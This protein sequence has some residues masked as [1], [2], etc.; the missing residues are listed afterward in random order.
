MET[1]A[2]VIFEVSFEVC[3]KVGGIYAV[4]K[5]K[6]ARMMEHYKENYFLIGPYFKERAALETMK[7]TPPA[8]MKEAFSELEK[9]GIKC[10]Y[11][12]WLIPS[13]PNVILIDY[14]QIMGNSNKLKEKLWQDYKID[15]W[16]AG[17]DFDEPV[18][19]S[20]AAGM[21]IEKLAGKM[22]NKKIVCQF[23]EWLSG[24]GMLYLKGKV[25]TVFTTHATMLGRTIAGSG[26]DL[27]SEVNSGKPID[28]KRSYK[29]GMQ[30][31]HLTEKA[32]AESCNVFTTVS[33]ITGKEAEYILGKKPDVLLPNGLDSSKF[34]TMEEL[35]LSHRKYR[36]KIKDFLNAYFGPYYDANLWDCM[37][38][39]T[40][41]RYEI[42]NKGYDVFIDALGELNNRMKKENTKKNVFA[43]F[44]IP[45]VNSGPNIDLL[46]SMKLYED[47][48]DEI[49][50]EMPWIEEKITESMVKGK[51]PTTKSIFKREFLEELK[52]K[53]IA[54]KKKGNPPMS[55]FNIDS[56][57]PIVKAFEKSGLTNKKSDKVKVIFYPSY[58]S[59][60]DKLLSLNYEQAVQGTHL[61]VFPSYYEPWGYTPLDAAENGVLSIT[62][63]LSGFGKFIKP[64]LKGKEGIMILERE[65][66]SYEKIVND[67][68]EMLWKVTTMKRSDRIPKKAEA[69]DLAALS[70]WKIMVKNY[71]EAH[72]LALEKF[73]KVK[74]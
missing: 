57:D 67:L 71:V 25:P 58:L 51:M 13:K 12:K 59:T 73:C 40:S 70:D 41:G 11:G 19:W 63:D 22:K 61:G 39:F 21:L 9:E 66:K 56:N 64:Y 2:D 23:H 33:E 38:F 32:C 27:Y 24:A 1:K 69:K 5:S 74:T 3:N 35:A 54:F 50:D 17:Y 30:A 68:A 7:Q 37:L 49:K 62:S 10:F 53:S 44:F 52:R 36:K 26:E 28:P 47:M 6:A 14:S 42:R 48:E 65:N 8:F 46:E 43:F 60:T 34:P 18:V 16:T 72:N 15:S 29:Y 31:K 55:A 4:L 45:R 20:T